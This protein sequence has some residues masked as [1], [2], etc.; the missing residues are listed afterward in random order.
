MGVPSTR[1]LFRQEAVEFQQ[2]SHLWGRVVPIQSLSVRLTVW[3]ITAS[4]AAIVV[5]LFVAQ[6]A[7][8]ETVTG[9]LTPAAGTARVFAP[10][11]GTV[12]TVHVVQG[13]RVK[14]GQLL[15]SVTIDQIAAN[16]EDV[17]AT[18][19]TTLERQKQS[20]TQQIT[21]EEQRD[22]SERNRL[23][24]QMR[25]LASDLS[26]ITAQIALQRERVRI[27]EKIVASG[28][29]LVTRGLV[30]EIDQRRR[31]DAFVEQKI[32]LNALEQT[33]NERQSQLTEARFTLEQLPFVTAAKIQQLR[34]ELWAAEQRVA[35]IN[36]RRAYMIKAPIAGRVSSL[37]A[38][39]GQI[40]DS[41]RLQLEIIPDDSM[42]QAE[43][44]IPTR[45]IG[46]VEVGQTV[47]IQYE[48]FPYQHYG[49]YRGRIVS[50]SQTMVTS[51]DMIVPVTLTGPAYRAVVSLDRPDIDAYGKRV[52]LQP[53]M[54]L[55]AKI[56]LD[57][58][59]LVE[60]ILNPLLSIRAQ[61]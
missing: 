20:V 52:P 36:G 46:F 34:S 57:R 15:L 24:A 41:K 2:Q 23:V 1:P 17:N 59:T 10:Q 54:L 40:A 37:Q 19:L 38:S 50:I 7:R 16:G 21:A 11:P 51:N 27:V 47:K 60:W 35:E 48:A 6:Y 9:Y 22:N 18:L 56:I 5:F 4:A 43:L 53:D 32:S 29:Q 25:G 30:S 13:Q 44:L 33:M 26:N 12:S 45:A 3:S 58:R 31:E 42:L 39:V 55:T 49:T 8:K 14:E 28:A 61:G